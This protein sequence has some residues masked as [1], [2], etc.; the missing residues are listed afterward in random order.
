[1]DN[2]PQPNEILAILRDIGIGFFGILGGIA[3]ALTVVSFFGLN[4]SWV[5]NL[6][7]FGLLLCLSP[8]LTGAILYSIFRFVIRIYKSRKV[9]LISNEN[10]IERAHKLPVELVKSVEVSYKAKNWVETVRY[11][12]LLS[13]PLFLSGMYQERVNIGKM[14]EDAAA[15][16]RMYEEQVVALVDD[17]GWTNV[18]LGNLGRAERHISDG[19]NIALE[20]GLFYFAA[21]GERH[22]AGIYQMYRIDEE[23]ALVQ[24]NSHYEKALS[25]AER[26]TD[27][28][29]KEEMR[30]GILYGRADLLIIQKD[31]TSALKIATESKEI[32]ENIGG[33]EERLVK[34][35]S[36][37]GRIYLGLTQ[38]QSAKDFFSAGYDEAYRLQR[39]D[40]IGNNLLGLGEVNLINNEYNLA[41]EHLKGALE[42]FEEIG[43][44]QEARRAKKLIAEAE[45]NRKMIE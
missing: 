20:K 17:L 27:T 36:Q 37:F 23:G 1:M 35:R 38:I 15:K 22:L 26:I 13:R 30:A 25:Y 24:A 6:G 28:F 9:N 43:M 41:L 42:I 16:A 4:I 31:Y 2:D 39:S 11:G 7:I 32:Y 44:K 34:S 5:I 45:L 19:V 40:E 33:Q 14:I 18:K 8:T 3:T 29:D 10:E 12:S 21:K